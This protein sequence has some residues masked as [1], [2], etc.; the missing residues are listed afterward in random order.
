MLEIYDWGQS[1]TSLKEQASNGL[2]FSLRGKKVL[3]K[4]IV[5]SGPKGLEPIV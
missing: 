5:Q 4:A 3:S 1:G 2:D